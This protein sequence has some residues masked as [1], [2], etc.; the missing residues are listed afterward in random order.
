MLK[1]LIRLAPKLVC[2]RAP[3]GPSC[4]NRAAATAAKT[5][6]SRDA[7]T[8]TAADGTGPLHA[9]DAAAAPTQPAPVKR[10][11]PVVVSASIQGAFCRAYRL[12]ARVPPHRWEGLPGHAVVQAVL[13]PRALALSTAWP[14]AGWEHGLSCEWQRHGF[15]TST[16][17][18]QHAVVSSMS[19]M[20]HMQV[21][22]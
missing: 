4:Y 12:S 21:C 17:D 16:C 22:C 20:A 1:W 5:T 3:Q 9:S 19:C 7:T 13:G 15:K 10:L 18:R 14:A 2:I 6:S 11:G 8:A